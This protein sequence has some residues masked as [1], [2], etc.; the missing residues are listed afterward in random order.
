VDWRGYDKW[1]KRKLRIASHALIVNQAIRAISVNRNDTAHI[2]R[3]VC[4]FGLFRM[5]QASDPYGVRGS[6]KMKQINHVL[7]YLIG[8]LFLVVMV[9]IVKHKTTRWD[10][11]EF[12]EREITWGSDKYV[13]VPEEIDGKWFYFVTDSENGDLVS[14]GRWKFD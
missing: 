3:S 1:V 9:Y 11:I 4:A 13:S 5:H 10:T 12:D 2:T 8:V 6:R 7:S 14:A